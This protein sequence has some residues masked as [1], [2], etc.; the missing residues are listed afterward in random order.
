MLD[1]QAAALRSPLACSL[2]CDTVSLRPQEIA[3]LQIKTRLSL[4]AYDGDG[5][6][7]VECVGRPS[8]LIQPKLVLLTTQ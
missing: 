4:Y 3:A 5:I 1:R 6:Y 2:K 7:L 8:I